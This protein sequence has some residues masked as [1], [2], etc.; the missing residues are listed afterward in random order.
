MIVQALI[1]NGIETRMYSAGALYKHKFYTDI[2]GFSYYDDVSDVI[3]DKGLF[4]PN[5]HCLTDEDIHF[6]CD[7]VKKAL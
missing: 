2:Y 7:I 5:H 4:L 6:I 3:H 1:N